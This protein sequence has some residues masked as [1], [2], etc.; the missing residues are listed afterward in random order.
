M[1]PILENVQRFLVYLGA[2]SV[3]A[4]LVGILASWGTGVSLAEAT[5]FALPVLLVYAVM[6]LASLYLCRAFPLQ[7]TRVAPLLLF[8]SFAAFLF[9]CIWLLFAYG[10]AVLLS[11]VADLTGAESR[12]DL[13]VPLLV[14]T[15]VLLFLL[16]VVLHYLIIAFEHSKLA[17]RRAFEHQILAREAELRALRSQIQPHFLFNSLNSICALTA[18]DPAAAR[19]MTIRLADFF[20]RTLR[21]GMNDTIP[22]AEELAMAE[23]FLAIE[24]ARFGE[25]LAF[26][27]IKGDD[28]DMCG[29]PSLL[30]QPLI[31]N[32]INHGIGQLLE[33]G[34]ITIEAH[35]SDQLLTLR[36]S[37]PSDREPAGG[38]G[39]KLGLEN[40]RKR[41]QASY[42]S[43]G[44]L[45]V[46]HTG[47]RFLAEIILP[48]QLLHHTV[49]I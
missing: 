24:Q 17:E 31:E 19:T 6:C 14:G 42:G 48:V 41:L 3:L 27:T 20:R 36:I 49:K 4:L 13:L 45:S 12:F 11:R 33:G 18:H 32:A 25:R 30:L 5:A 44:R 46:T 28:V 37:N 7:S 8:H 22:L 40:V 2:W 23:N 9:A 16:S 21:L 1:H 15:G 38:S 34:T 39:G 26:K 35:R 10:W 29:V 47:N 43:E